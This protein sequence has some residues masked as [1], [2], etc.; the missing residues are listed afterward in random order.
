M[1]CISWWWL[2]LGILTASALGSIP[3]WETRI[4]QAVGYSQK[5]KKTHDDDMCDKYVA[6][7]CT[8]S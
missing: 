4:L 6:V 3:G 1:V 2:G 8:H 5:K 7:G